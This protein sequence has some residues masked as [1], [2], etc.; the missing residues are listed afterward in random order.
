MDC[1]RRNFGLVRYLL[2]TPLPSSQQCSTSKIFLGDM[3]YIQ[4]RVFTSKKAALLQKRMKI[5]AR[6][7]AR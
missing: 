7:Q 6:A 1:L 5:N 3:Y 4:S 2:E